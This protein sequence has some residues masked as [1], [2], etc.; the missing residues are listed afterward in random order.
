MEAHSSQPLEDRRKNVYN[1]SEL[2]PVI[3]NVRIFSNYYK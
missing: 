1:D 2:K 3:L